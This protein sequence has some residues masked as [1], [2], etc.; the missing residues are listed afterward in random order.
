MN[1]GNFLNTKDIDVKF[2]IIKKIYNFY[3][4]S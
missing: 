2:Q 1:N 3:K 4:H